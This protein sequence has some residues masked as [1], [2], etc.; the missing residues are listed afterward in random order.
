[1]VMLSF[2]E[3]EGVLERKKEVGIGKV[4]WAGKLEDRSSKQDRA[5]EW[6]VHGTCLS[7]V[8]ET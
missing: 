8:P 5:D 6:I 1:M 2:R 4:R 3:V 7:E